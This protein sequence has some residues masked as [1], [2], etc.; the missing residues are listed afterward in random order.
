MANILLRHFNLKPGESREFTMCDWGNAGDKQDDFPSYKI[1]VE[2]KGKEQV[3]VPAGT[4][5]ANHVVQ[6]Q[7][8]SADTWFKKRQEHV[9]DFWYLDD[10]LIIRILRHREPYEVVLQS[11]GEPTSASTQGAQS[12]ESY[13]ELF[14]QIT[15][16][17]FHPF[18]GRVID[19]MAGASEEKWQALEQNPFMQAFE[20][21]FGVSGARV[22][23]LGDSVT[24]TTLT[25][26]NGAF[27]FAKLPEGAYQLVVIFPANADGKE[28]IRRRRLSLPQ[29][30]PFQMEIRWP[31]ITIEGQVVDPT[32]KPIAGAKVTGSPDPQPEAAEPLLQSPKSAVTDNEG[33]FRLQDIQPEQSLYRIAGY[34]NGGDLSANFN[35]GAFFE[36]Q[37]EA[38]GYVQKE[39]PK[40]PLIVE[41]QL[42]PARRLWQAVNKAQRAE[43][44]GDAEIPT[45]MRALD[46]QTQGKTITGLRIV[47]HPDGGTALDGR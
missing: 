10:Y 4:F 18:E 26:D 45:Q 23:L 17:T 30:R 42:K 6:T 20:N 33:K 15:R 28:Q 13:E 37:V 47:L 9:T 12:Q 35:Y 38:Q 16:R 5:E 2:H 41:D 7:L 22:V 46:Y 11:R 32:G 39:R 34:L 25:G 21:I 31:N 40:V 8:T 3:T 19:N 43:N 36:F 14:D 1:R 24:T 29:E 44:P 27:N